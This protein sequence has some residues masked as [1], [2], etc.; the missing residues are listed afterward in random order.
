MVVTIILGV[1]NVLVIALIIVQRRLFRNKIHEVSKPIMV[2]EQIV[3][4]AEM[5]PIN[6]FIAYEFVNELLKWANAHD[7]KAIDIGTNQSKF[8]SNILD[9][10]TVNAKLR[11]IV[12]LIISRMSDN[13][14]A[15]FYL[16]YSCDTDATSGHDVLIEYV[17]RMCM[18]MVRKVVVEI[19]SA[20][21]TNHD[22]QRTSSEIVDQYMLAL[23]SNIYNKSG[24]YTVMPSSGGN[25]NVD[26]KSAGV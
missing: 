23:E 14:K 16:I 15:Q 1:L 20:V 6:E 21:L 17:V 18:M 24:I 5:A 26:A 22:S 19:T 25:E 2:P 8:V 7:S 12:P 13:L 9:G 4:G 3:T 10:E 11:S